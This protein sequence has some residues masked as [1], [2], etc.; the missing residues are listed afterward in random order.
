M[1]HRRDFL[2]QI[3]A[4]SA[5]QQSPKK[6]TLLCV[7]AHMDDCE[8]MAGGLILKAV[9]EGLRVVLVEAVSD[10][11]NWPTAQGREKKVEEG[12]KRIAK[13]TGVEK[14]LLGYKYHHVPVDHALK[15]RI[16]QIVADVK[17]DIAVIMSENDYWTDHSNIARAAK[18]GIMFVHGYLGRSIASPPVILA[19]SAGAN[20]TYDFRPD[21]FVDVTDVIEGVSNWLTKLDGLLTDGSPVE[22]TLVLKHAGKTLEMS[23]GA[24]RVVAARTVWGE[25]SGVRYAEAFRAI[26][27]GPS[28]LW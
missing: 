24:E 7:G 26:R 23:R 14:I 28:Q 2:M 25:M 15:L 3:S 11:S 6:K 19:G 22:A 4:V 5:A 16:A 8:W 9:R 20:Q 13:E 12:V 18:D 17:P 1:I 10:W 21:T 27:K